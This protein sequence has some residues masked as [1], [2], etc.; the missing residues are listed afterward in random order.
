MGV[1]T[2]LFGLKNRG[3]G[4]EF[5]VIERADGSIAV[6]AGEKVLVDSGVTPVTAVPSDPRSANNP[7]GLVLNAGSE[8]IG[9]TL[10]TPAS[11]LKIR[12]I[13][14]KIGMSIGA[15]FDEAST[16][17]TS[18]AG[19][20]A[21]LRDEADLW[22]PGNSLKDSRVWTG[23][24]TWSLAAADAAIALCEAEGKAARGHTLMYPDHPPSWQNSSNVTSANWRDLID[25]HMAQM[26]PRYP[27]L[28][29][30]D[31]IN[32]LFLIN[33]TA[34]FAG[35][36]K[37]TVWMQAAQDGDAL[38]AHCF[39]RARY[40]T[41]KNIPLF[42]CD[43]G[44]EQGSDSSRNAQKNN[45]VA[46]LTRAKAAGV[47]VD[48]FNSQWHIVVTKD[49]PYRLDRA[50]H[51]D[52]LK[53]LVDLGLIINVTEIDVRMQSG[54]WPGSVGEYDR[55]AA[56]LLAATLETYF[57][58]VPEAQ[59]QHISFWELSDKYHSWKTAISGNAW[60]DSERPCPFDW[61]FVRKPIYTAALQT[62]LGVA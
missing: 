43:N 52:F 48:G 11:T 29:G 3:D 16:S 53:A 56:E 2:E 25:A 21:L 47:P 4:K 36:Y 39:E 7:R 42:Y 49:Y 32:E 31:V 46:A 5:R 59:R 60:G 15:A 12:D 19:Y 54:G 41:P 8:S 27:N 51:R 13:G 55:R 33:T 24:N 35:G 20:A 61:G 37:D 45:I 38:L 10:S 18:D 40:Y 9:P 14:K 50:K 44:T 17:W 30:W 26:C 28:V 58:V 34:P 6:L 1:E 62:L 23:P 22:T 57:T